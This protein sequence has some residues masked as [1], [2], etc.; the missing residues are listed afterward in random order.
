MAASI[1]RALSA[2]TASTESASRRLNRGGTIML[3]PRKSIIQAILALAFTAGIGAIH[4]E[5]RVPFKVPAEET[6][7]S[8]PVGEAIRLGRTLITDTRK[9]LPENVGNEI[10]RASCRER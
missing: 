9:Q 5:E 1:S 10:G 2:R 3:R 8:G 4:A 6:I 7:P